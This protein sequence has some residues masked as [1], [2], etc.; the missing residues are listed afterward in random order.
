M[1]TKSEMRV[2][3]KLS[4]LGGKY[5]AHHW[6]NTDGRRTSFVYIKIKDK[7]YYG[8]SQCSRKDKFDKRLGRAIALGR[9]M[10]NYDKEYNTSLRDV[11][12]QMKFIEDKCEAIKLD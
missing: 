9:A 8:E 11:P 5:K 12:E 3:N 1:K 4:V 6:G 7:Y 2:L 10:Q